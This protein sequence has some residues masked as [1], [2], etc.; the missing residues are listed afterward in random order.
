MSRYRTYELPQ[1]Y[2]AGINSR[3]VGMRLRT[4]MN[5][6]KQLSGERLRAFRK[7]KKIVDPIWD[8]TSA[9]WHVPDVGQRATLSL[10][11]DDKGTAAACIHVDKKDG[12]AHAQIKAL[13]EEYP[14]AIV[15]EIGAGEAEAAYPQQDI[16]RKHASSGLIQPGVSISHGRYRSGTLGCVVEVEGRDRNDICVV[17]AAHVVA[18]NYKSVQDGD[19]IYSP[20]KGNTPRLLRQHAIGELTDTVT[21]LY[22]LLGWR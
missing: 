20:G 10:T 8:T 1:F 17:T 16:F 7:M 14:G 18:L 19:A 11:K 2:A 3:P 5:L 21:D 4:A 6:E 12:W 13:L 15:A 22:P 9:N